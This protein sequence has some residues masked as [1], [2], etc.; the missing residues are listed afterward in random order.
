MAEDELVATARAVRHRPAL[1]AVRRD[2]PDVVAVVDEHRPVAVGPAGEAVGSRVVRRVVLLVGETDVE[3]PGQV[4]RPAVGD[5]V[6]EPV[7][8]VAPVIGEPGA[9]GGEAGPAGALLEDLLPR[10]G[11]DV[12]DVDVLVALVP[13]D[14][15]AVGEVGRAERRPAVLGEGDGGHLVRGQ[16][17]ERLLLR[18]EMHDARQG[19]LLLLLGLRL[20]H[21]LEVGV[22]PVPDVDLDGLGRVLGLGLG[23]G[24]D[25]EEQPSA[26][27]GELEPS[28]L[29]DGHP[30]R[31]ALGQGR[32]EL[33]GGRGRR[34]PVV[35]LGGRLLGLVVVA[36]AGEGELPALLVEGQVLVV[37]QALEQG[38]RPA[39]RRLEGEG[40]VVLRGLG[41]HGVGQP[42]AGLVPRVVGGLGDRRLL[43]RGQ[44]ADDEVGAGLLLLLFLFLRL[45]RLRLLRPGLGLDLGFGL[46][47]RLGFP[48]LVLRL[49][50]RRL[51]QVGDE[52]PGFL[53]DLEALDPL[54]RGHLARGQVH[55]AEAGLGLLLGLLLVL[56]G[57]VDVG[58]DGG[59]REH[60]VPAV[61]GDDGPAAARGA[62]LPVR[63]QVADDEL[64]VP[65]L[66]DEGVGEPPPVARELGPLDGA[67]AV[68]GVVAQGLFRRRGVAARRGERQGED[69]DEKDGFR[70]R[71]KTLHESLRKEWIRPLAMSR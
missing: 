38:D 30:G 1:G 54:D 29:A 64:S 33:D 23:G 14:E 2:L 55:D 68:V 43:A 32:D 15:L 50:E 34:R 5:P 36:V 57:L 46:G 39:G 40:A 45:V 19:P 47:L 53:G 61:G 18:P 48:L 20:L 56:L 11:R 65:V 3:F 13:G 69:E 26:V 10:A 71:E 62:V 52:G 31:E 4:E 44:L 8:A 59:D 24:G 6:G 70:G 41:R 12:D 63:L 37:A 66:G 17:D 28:V 58:L 9:A 25:A 22:L 67:P 7:V 60:D 35:E 49:L 16:P 42:G 51:E 27:L 21:G